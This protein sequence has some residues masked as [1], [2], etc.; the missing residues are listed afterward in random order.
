MIV[1]ASAWRGTFRLESQYG[2]PTVAHVVERYFQ[3]S[4]ATSAKARPGWYATLD[5]VI[6]HVDRRQKARC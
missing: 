3:L 4:S 1:T 6:L 5:E 2:K